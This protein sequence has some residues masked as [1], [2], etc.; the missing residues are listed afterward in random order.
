MSKNVQTLYLIFTY[1]EKFF[2]TILVISLCIKTEK[3]VMNHYF[4]VTLDIVKYI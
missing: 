2:C 4:L 1:H 3:F